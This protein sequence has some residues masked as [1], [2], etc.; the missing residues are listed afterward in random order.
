MTFNLPLKRISKAKYTRLKFDFEKLKDPN[1]L[2]TLQA[3]IGG[4]FV[5]LTIMNNE[6]TNMD[7][8]I[9]LFNPAVTETGSEITG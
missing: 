3:M 1:V 5:P 4:K 7:S 6:D 9:T 2:E 8:V